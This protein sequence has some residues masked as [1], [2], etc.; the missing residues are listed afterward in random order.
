MRIPIGEYVLRDYRRSDVEALVKYANSARV[1]RFLRDRFPQPYTRAD[2]VAWIRQVRERDVGTVLAIATPRELIGSIGVYP[3]DDVYRRSAELGYW[4]ADPFWG[5]GIA[6]SAVEAV[7]KI[8]FTTTSL[9]RIFACVFEDNVPSCR[10][11]E[12]CGFTLEGVHRKA[13]FKGGVFA[14]EKVY[15]LLVEEWTTRRSTASPEVG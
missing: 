1:A 14:D 6:T 8:A 4:V 12:N 9:N 3:K 5:R 13:V 10:V 7:C 2:A 15:A 11:L